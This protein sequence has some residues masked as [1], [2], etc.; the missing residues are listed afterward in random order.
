MKENTNFYEEE[1]KLNEVLLDSTST[2]TEMADA[3]DKFFE[4]W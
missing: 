2:Y 4:S 3:I 1:R